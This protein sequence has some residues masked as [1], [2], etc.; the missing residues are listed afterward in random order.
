MG[1]RL[2]DTL[3][4]GADLRGAA[5]DGINWRG[6]DPT[7]ARLDVVQAVSFARAHG[8]LVTAGLAAAGP[9]AGGRRHLIAP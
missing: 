7:G 3:L 5:T 8:A 1:A 2:Q 4:R 9:P 6:F